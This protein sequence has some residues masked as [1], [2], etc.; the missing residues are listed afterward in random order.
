MQKF[1]E[2]LTGKKSTTLLQNKKA[3]EGAFC[4]SAHFRSLR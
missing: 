4:I 2:L 3:P 1:L